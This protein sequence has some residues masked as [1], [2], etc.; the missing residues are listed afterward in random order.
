M[1]E[2]ENRKD[3]LA[4]DVSTIDEELKEKNGA[5]ASLEKE[6]SKLRE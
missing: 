2:M 1:K 3:H 6:V 4:Q 5:R